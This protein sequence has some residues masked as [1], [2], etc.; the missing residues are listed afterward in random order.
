[1]TYRGR[2][3]GEEHSPFALCDE[4]GLVT[5]A[6]RLA[7]STFLQTDALKTDALFAKSLIL[8]T[9]SLTRPGRGAFPL[10]PLRRA[11]PCEAYL[12]GRE[13]F[14]SAESSALRMGSGKNMLPSVIRGFSRTTDVEFSHSFTGWSH[15]GHSMQVMEIQRE[16]SAGSVFGDVAWNVA[17]RGFTNTVASERICILP[18]CCHAVLRPTRP[19]R[20]AFPLR[21]LRR[22]RLRE[23]IKCGH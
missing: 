20:G 10:R 7:K 2:G 19:G 15:R 3:R 1:M 23:A 8:M 5:P 12:T 6:L 13:L 16:Q 22:A 18:F 11:R 21:P 14:P 4:P 9:N 17:R